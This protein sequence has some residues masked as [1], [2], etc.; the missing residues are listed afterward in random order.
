[1]MMA[2]RTTSL[3][4]SS[5]ISRTVP[6]VRLFTRFS[7]AARSSASVMPDSSCSSSSYRPHSQ[8]EYAAQAGTLCCWSCS[9]AALVQPR[10]VGQLFN[11][12]RVLQ[13]ACQ[14]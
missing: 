6:S 7:A 2:S 10:Q 12:N 9:R 5:A 11:T 3:R 4:Y 14:L 8:Q 1:M 13:E